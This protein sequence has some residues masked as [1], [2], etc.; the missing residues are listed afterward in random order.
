MLAHAFLAVTA[1]TTRADTTA[2]PGLI[3]LTANEI[4]HLF[5]NLPDDVR[6]SAAHL[7]P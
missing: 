4:R 1:V 3:A 6:H 7:L 5:T 2:P